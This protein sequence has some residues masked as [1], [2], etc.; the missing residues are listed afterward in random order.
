MRARQPAERGFDLRRKSAVR[1]VTRQREEQKPDLLPVA[2]GWLDGPLG[3]KLQVQKQ[4]RCLKGDLPTGLWGVLLMRGLHTPHQV[5]VGALPGSGCSD[6]ATEVACLLRLALYRATAEA[7]VPH[8]SRGQ[9][10]TQQQLGLGLVLCNRSDQT[11]PVAGYL[12]NNT[13]K[14]VPCNRSPQTRAAACCICICIR[15]PCR[16]P[17]LAV[18]HPGTALPLLFPA[19]PPPF[20]RHIVPSPRCTPAP[21][22]QTTPAPRRAAL[23]PLPLCAPAAPAAVPGAPAG[24]SLRRRQ[25]TGCAAARAPR[26]RAAPK[27]GA[28]PQAAPPRWPLAPEG[29]WRWCCG[30]I[31]E[32]RGQGRGKGGNEARGGGRGDRRVGE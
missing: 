27:G 9:V 26:A 3:I 21:T 11:R 28:R 19:S 12:C 14:L 18:C 1:G 25:T 6:G 5:G 24:V 22:A 8:D 32:G 29:R 7:G 31:R 23:H 15:P 13:L 10:C 20:P 30:Q 16:R 17:S 2:P 4:Q